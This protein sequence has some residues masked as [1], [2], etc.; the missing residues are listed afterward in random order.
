MKLTP[1][2]LSVVAG[3]VASA[4]VAQAAS[5]SANCRA[6]VTGPSLGIGTVHCQ[7]GDCVGKGIYARLRPQTRAG[8]AGGGPTSWEFTVE[9]SLWEIYPAGPAAGRIDDGDFL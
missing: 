9:P 5:A 7:G 1:M 2:V 4:A 8:G 6:P 3:F